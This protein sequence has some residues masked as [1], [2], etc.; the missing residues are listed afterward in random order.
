LKE[1]FLRP[2]IEAKMVGA[3]GVTEPSA[4]SD[5]FSIRTT[6]K[7]DGDF[8]VVNGRKI[9]ITNGTQADYITLLTKTDAEQGHHGFTLLVVPTDS[10]GFGV[11]K[12]L[13]KIG[14]H[15]SDTAELVFED[16]RV[17]VENR[18]GEEGYGFIYQMK[19]F[20]KE[21]MVAAHRR[22]RR[23]AD[24]ARPHRAVHQGPH[25]VRQAAVAQAARAVHLAELQTDIE[26]L[27]QL[28]Y[29]CVRMHV[30]RRGVH[31]RNVD[32]QARRRPHR[33]QR[34]RLVHPVPRRLRLHGRVPVSRY[35]RDSRLLS[36]GGGADE[37]MMQIICQAG[38]VRERLTADMMSSTQRREAQSPD[39]SP[40][41]TFSV[42]ASL[43]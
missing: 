33:A 40:L 7:R 34:R 1:R 8:Y 19:Q 38:R 41:R 35:W 25:G 32:G 14:N 6:A 11:A 22:G 4:G 23:R 24:D 16:V 18:I 31:A 5:V 10:P 26:M 39:E 13:E 12:K 29:H 43:R 9:F 42:S 30:R 37:V 27:R 36:I 15:C 21:R 3:I 17:P 28:N 20:Q 2:S